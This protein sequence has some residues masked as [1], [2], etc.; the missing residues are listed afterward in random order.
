MDHDSDRN[1]QD[2]ADMLTARFGGVVEKEGEAEVEQHVPA[3]PPAPESRIR[4]PEREYPQ[5]RPSTAEQFAEIA[6]RR[7]GG[8][9]FI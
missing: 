2:F 4:H 9:N 5:L 7:L 3:A 8:P 1:A 6:A